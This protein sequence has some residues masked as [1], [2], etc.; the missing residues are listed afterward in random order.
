MG[1]RALAR[2][3]FALSLES[4]RRVL[5]RGSPRWD[6][7]ARDRTKAGQEPGPV[8][9]NTSVSTTAGSGQKH[10]SPVGR[11]GVSE[12]TDGSGEKG[13]RA[14]QDPATPPA[15]R[16]WAPSSLASALG[17]VRSKEPSLPVATSTG[18]DRNWGLSLYPHVLWGA[19]WPGS[20]CGATC[21]AQVVVTCTG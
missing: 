5:L 2:G 3:L 9:P 4:W 17:Q 20:P 21:M 15:S 10:H 19:V 13:T 18:L 11:G 8:T 14:S 12:G 6:C 7:A 16:R 1:L